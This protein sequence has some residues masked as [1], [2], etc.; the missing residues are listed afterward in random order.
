MLLSELP[1]ELILEIYQWLYDGMDNIRLIKDIARR[2]LWALNVLS[3]CSIC[4][5]WFSVGSDYLS[6]RQRTLPFTLLSSLLHTVECPTSLSLFQPSWTHLLLSSKQNRLPF[7]LQV[8][9]IVLN[10]TLLLKPTSQ[11]N[12]IQ[13]Q[14][15]CEQPIATESL[16]ASIKIL[17]DTCPNVKTVEILYDSQYTP[18]MANRHRPSRVL[19]LPSNIISDALTT[20]CMNHHPSSLLTFENQCTFL[21]HLVFTAREPIQRC[22]CCTGRGWDH[23]LRPL[24]QQLPVST[25]ELD[26]VLPSRSVLECLAQNQRIHTLVIRGGIL[27]Q[28]SRLA[29]YGTTISTPPRFPTD[30][31]SR[32]RILE[33]YLHSNN[34]DEDYDDDNQLDLLAMFRQTYDMVHPIKSLKQLIIHG[35]ERYKISS[36]TSTMMTDSMISKDVWNKLELLAERHHQLDTFILKNIPGFQGISEQSRLKCLFSRVNLVDVVYSL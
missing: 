5:S 32:I 17:L 35:H 36:S 33:I 23:T 34:D 25:L 31:L 22:P 4:R 2:R 7:H 11:S 19:A 30:L 1:P 13:Q 12:L 29:R 9:Q 3:T 15:S 20:H 10:L 28:A 14:S 26:H 21:S 6:I 16:S 18:R 27:I 24:L 8:R